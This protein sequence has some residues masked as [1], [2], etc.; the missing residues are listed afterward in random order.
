MIR[1]TTDSSID[2]RRQ[3]NN[4]VTVSKEKHS[5]FS[6]MKMQTLS[7]KIWENFSP[8]GGET[9]KYAKRNSSEWRKMKTRQ[10]S[11]ARESKEENGIWV[12]NYIS[13]QLAEYLNKEYSNALWVSNTGNEKY[14]STSTEDEC[15]C[16][17]EQ[18]VLESH[19]IHYV[20]SVPLIPDSL[21]WARMYII[22]WAAAEKK[23]IKIKKDLKRYSFNMS[24]R[25]ISERF[26]AMCKHS[27][28][29][30][31]SHDGAQRFLPRS[32]FEG[33][34]GGQGGCLRG[35]W[36]CVQKLWNLVVTGSLG[37]GQPQ[38]HTYLCMVQPHLLS[39]CSYIVP[40]LPAPCGRPHCFLSPP[41]T[42]SQILPQCSSHAPG[43]CLYWGLAL[44]PLG[45][46]VCPSHFSDGSCTGFHVGTVPPK[47][48]L[49]SWRYQIVSVISIF[50]PSVAKP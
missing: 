33:G 29:R 46:H 20:S 21:G 37:Q 24:C 36:S 42:C 48:M 15:V 14:E 49:S 9:S 8:A 11:E 7:D 26:P 43:F 18:C 5:V 35:G 40:S 28:G 27:E 44:P 19:I 32:D 2:I 1:I 30:R 25:D 47:D 6:K 39:P 23:K 13:F 41:S 12:G 3:G 16:E 22:S 4:I 31:L 10:K 38:S 34:A 45:P 50:S 17:L